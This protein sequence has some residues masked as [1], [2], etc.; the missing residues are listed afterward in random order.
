MRGHIIRATGLHAL[1]TNEKVAAIPDSAVNS[2]KTTN[3]GSE[4]RVATSIPETLRQFDA[5]FT[6]GEMFRSAPVIL[7][8]P[9][10]PVRPTRSLRQAWTRFINSV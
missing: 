3:T 1:L 6:S 2:Y 7:E 5:K 4:F 9:T 10:T 8:F